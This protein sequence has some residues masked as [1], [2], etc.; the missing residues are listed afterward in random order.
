MAPATSAPPPP[1]VTRTFHKVLFATGPIAFS[2]LGPVG[3]VRAGDLAFRVEGGKLVQ[4][5]AD[6]VLSRAQSYGTWPKDIVSEVLI[7]RAE[8]DPHV[9]AGKLEGKTL[10]TVVTPGES[11]STAFLVRGSGDQWLAAVLNGKVDWRW[12][13]ATTKAG[14]TPAVAP[15]TK[16]EGP[17]KTPFL[18]DEGFGAG[19]GV[20]VA[21]GFPCAAQKTDRAAYLARWEADGK[22]PALTKLSDVKKSSGRLLLAGRK[23]LPLY[24]ASQH[25]AFLAEHRDKQVVPIPVPEPVQALALAPNGTLYVSA[26]SKLYERKP[27]GPFEPI[28]TMFRI[29]RVWVDDDGKLWLVSAVEETGKRAPENPSADG[30]DIR[31]R[32]LL[33]DAFAPARL[34]VAPTSAAVEAGRE[35]GIELGT[36]ACATL[37]VRVLTGVTKGQKLP[38]VGDIIKQVDDPSKVRFVL[39]EHAKGKLALTAI[40]ADLPTGRRV[41]TLAGAKIA[42]AKPSTA[43]PK[44]ACRA[45]VERGTVEASP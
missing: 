29:E 37:S 22:E 24:V 10:T 39:D 38:I 15:A 14:P 1:P 26:G 43:K 12:A 7:E 18:P 9:G 2:S 25:E 6:A 36:E 35:E 3:I 16:T 8:M 17:C 20:I 45:P 5:P 11:E 32:E 27:G 42:T 33:T 23:G 4:D 40:V 44:V 31:P 19:D 34:V 28:A 41:A 21:V 30:P 13:N